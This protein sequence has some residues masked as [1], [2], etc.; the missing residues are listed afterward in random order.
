MI[1]TLKSIAYKPK[2]A[3]Q[4]ERGYQRLALPEARLVADY[5]IEN[6][7]KGG[8]PKRHL[9]VM[10]QITLTE[11]AAEGY[12]MGVG[13]LGENLILSGVDLRRLPQ[14]AHLQIGDEAVIALLAL[15]EPCEQLT[16]LDSRMP[17]A[18]EGRVGFMCRVVRGGLIRVGDAV[19]LVP[20]PESA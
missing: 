9:N 15:R 5:G 13:V 3:P 12:P 16:K 8:H 14:G 18:V 11:L 4:I 6:D 19:T 1:G 2:D 17:Q 20:Q 10:D 7:R